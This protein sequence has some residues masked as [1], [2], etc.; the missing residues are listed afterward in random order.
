[1]TTENSHAAATAG[2]SAME[3]VE[4]P[5]TGMTCANCAMTIERTLKR[6]V[7]GVLQAAVN[8]ASERASV[9]FD[10]KTAT[11]DDIIAAIRKAGYDALP[12]ANESDP[13]AA[14]AEQ[15]AR[16]AEIRDQERK[17]L[18]G[19]VFT[20]PLFVLS[21]S[22][23]FGLL[24]HWAHG[25]WVN[26]LFFALATPVQFYTAWDYYVGG[27]KSLGNRSANMDVLVA[28]GS[29]V[30][31]GYSV[32][33]L[34]SPDLGHHVY[35][36]TSAVIITLIKLG[37]VLE[38]RAKGKTGS[39]IRELLNLQPQTAT[40]LAAETAVE[41]PVSKIRA[42]DILLV[43]PGGRIPCDGIVIEGESAVDESMLTGEPIAVDKAPD[44]PVVGATINGFGLLKIRAVHVG[45][46][47]ALARIVRMVQQAQGSKAPVQALADKVAAI[48]VP[49]IIV[50]AIVT[51]IVWY[52]VTADIVTAMIRTV[53]VLVIACPCAL[54][55]AT[56]TAV[57]AGMGA[58]AKNGI[59]F[60]NSTGLQETARL[61][62]LV[63]DKTGT[64]TE[65]KPL[66]SAVFAAPSTMPEAFGSGMI[67]NASMGSP[68]D[69]QTEILRLAASAEQGSEH[70]LGKAIVQEAVKQGISLETI[71]R[72]QAFG[73]SGIEVL[74]GCG[75]QV[76]VG[77]PDWMREDGSAFL[78]ED[79]SAK[80]LMGW[81]EEQ[82]TL[83]RTPVIISVTGTGTNGK[84]GSH[85]K[86]SPVLLGAISLSDRLKTDAADAVSAIHALG[87]RTV[88]LTGDNEKTAAAI[89]AEA[90]IDQWRAGL[91]PDEKLDAID[92]LQRQGRVVGMVG[93]GIND[94]PA[95]A[96][97]HVGI[98]IGTGTDVAIESADVILTGGRLSG[99]A[100]AIRLSRAT[101]RTIR[102]NL[103]WAF[104]YNVVLIPIAAGVLY[105]FPDI[106]MAL[107]Q[108][109]PIL[110]ALAMAFSSVSVVTNS[111]RLSS[112]GIPAESLPA[113][114]KRD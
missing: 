24:G 9:D 35:F 106:P 54:G 73:G 10:P 25:W 51:G 95:L 111:L 109:H 105:P 32:I 44:S 98:A 72:F 97:A 15:Q 29:S 11:L 49:T 86:S 1:M 50:L 75:L 30:A 110:A 23:D 102:Q 43:R 88:M 108:L 18:V 76:R 107:R 3:R 20:L 70:P 96:Q 17:F 74:L 12:P 104:G 58:G 112:T 67:R 40:L 79:A 81:T 5:V 82:S 61:D 4:L 87:L 60:K 90:G 45:K 19:L 36:E 27:I 103:I 13:M 56:P 63:L 7:P 93:D 48:F 28:L 84:T 77:K 85:A 78:M 59:L 65:G 89:A 14:D 113:S 46:D 55:L 69:P 68:N 26:W 16:E 22:R 37:K 91:K 100:R 53:A 47:T 8:F 6:K 92:D 94:A 38:A 39:A 71:A 66:V 52:G 80:A 21:M 33:I 41:I 31:Y 57:M 114:S 42:G 99:I 83:G 2:P 34:L 62:I 64:L 101:L